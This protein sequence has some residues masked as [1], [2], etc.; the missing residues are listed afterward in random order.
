MAAAFMDSFMQ[1]LV[2][3]GFVMD[4][5]SLCGC[6]DEQIAEI[7]HR[8]NIQLPPVYK[9]FLLSMG[10]SSGD[11][12]TGSDLL[13]PEVLELRDD[14][15]ELLNESKADFALSES[16]FVF[17]MHQGWQF[18]FF[19][20]RAGDAAPIYQYSQG[21]DRPSKIFDSFSLWLES[22]LTDEVKSPHPD[23]HT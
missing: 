19:D 14:A 10:Q 21:D 23:A 17:C 20:C 3:N 11:F 4:D 1:R 9:S 13:F 15:E 12:L 7:E 5:T 2:A 18:M 16:D 6:D 22:I 8:F